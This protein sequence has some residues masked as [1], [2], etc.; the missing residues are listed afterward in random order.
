M[1][2]NLRW[3]LTRTIKTRQLLD[4][5][6]EALEAWR[7]IGLQ[8]SEKKMYFFWLHDVC[9][10]TRMVGKCENHTFISQLWQECI[11]IYWCGRS[12]LG[13]ETVMWVMKWDVFD[14]GQEKEFTHTH[15]HLPHCPCHP[16]KLSV[17]VSKYCCVSENTR[18]H[19][20]ALLKY[21]IK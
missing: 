3:T 5:L 20:T 9:K 14:S 21:H 15:T 18:Y 2:R 4:M 13:E 7:R 11:L 12:K 6:A 1:V 17:N 16:E 10:R 8:K 19:H